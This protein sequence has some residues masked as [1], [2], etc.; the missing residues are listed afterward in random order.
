[1]KNI[2]L[3]APHPDDEIVG[4]SI[5]IKRILSKKNLIIFFPTNGVIPKEAMA[6]NL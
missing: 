5:I 6:T 1:M 4:A 2:L 3:V